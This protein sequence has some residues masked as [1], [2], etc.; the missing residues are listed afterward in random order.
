MRH[1]TRIIVGLLA[2]AMVVGAGTAKAQSATDAFTLQPG[3]KATITFESFC[4]DYGKKFPDTIGLPPIDVAQPEVA[5]ALAYA[6]SKGYTGSQAKEVQ[7]AIWKARGAQGS[8]ETGAQGQEIT[9]NAANQPA[10]PAGA[11]SVID[12]LKNNQIKATAGTWQGIGEKLTIN[13]FEDNFQ[14]RGELMIENTSGQ[15]LTLYMPVGTVFPAPGPEFQSM[16]GYATNVEVDNPEMQ[17][18]QQLPNT[19]ISTPWGSQGALIVLAALASLGL[20]H[21]L[22]RR[23]RV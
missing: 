10:A 15:A 8:P 9:A 21:V 7:F 11:T 5:G 22:R 1:A 23:V 17:Q 12:A 20:G 2:L 16:A 18:M 6:L 13:N 4:I 14:G 3:G 19:G